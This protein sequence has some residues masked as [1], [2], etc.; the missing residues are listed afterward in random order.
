MTRSHRLSTFLLV[1]GFAVFILQQRVLVH[2]QARAN[3]LAQ[4]TSS[5]P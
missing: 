3:P 1:C 4:P 5:K 2:A